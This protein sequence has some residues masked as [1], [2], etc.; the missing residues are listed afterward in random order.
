MNNYLL[1]GILAVAFALFAIVY[2]SIVKNYYSPYATSLPNGSFFIT[3]VALNKSYVLAV[4]VPK[5]Q[6]QI[7]PIPPKTSFLKNTLIGNISLDKYYESN[8]Y[9]NITTE[10]GSL[11]M[12]ADSDLPFILT[13]SAT[14]PIGKFE[15]DN[16]T[17]YEYVTAFINSSKVGCFTWLNSNGKY[18]SA[19]PFFYNR[20]LYLLPD[21]L[22][23]YISYKT[24][25]AWIQ[26]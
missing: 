25:D 17:Y 21:Y 3:F 1:L 11:K 19:F 23:K 8:L 24:A 13:Y 4:Y 20:T 18:Y 15:Y 2:S 16:N 9:L 14:M 10:S 22:M 5:G 6:C 26:V 7:I 12:L